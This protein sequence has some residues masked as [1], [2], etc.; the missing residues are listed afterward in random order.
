MLYVFFIGEYETK[1]IDSSLTLINTLISRANV[2]RIG[3]EYIMLP[4]E[5]KQNEKNIIYLNMVTTKERKFQ[6]TK[7]K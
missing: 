2:I 1:Y 5:E 7:E 4:N 3:K 6:K